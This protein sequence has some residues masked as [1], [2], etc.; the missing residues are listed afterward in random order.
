MD[1]PFPFNLPLTSL[2]YMLLYLI[3]FVTH[4]L[5]MHYVVAGC[6]S[7][8]GFSFWYRQDEGALLHNP[9]VRVLRDWMPFALSAAITFGVAP[10]LFVQILVPL[11]FYTANLL[12]GWRWMVVIPALMAAFYLLYVLKSTWFERLRWWQRALVAGL[13]AGLFVFIGFCWTANHLVSSEPSAWTEA[14]ASGELPLKVLPVVSRSLVWLSVAFVSMATLL[15]AQLAYLREG[16]ATDDDLPTVGWLRWFAMA[17][18]G[19][20]GVASLAAIAFSQPGFGAV[21][22]LS[23]TLWLVLGILFWAGQ[24]YLWHSDSQATSRRWI[25]PRL[26]LLPGMLFCGAVVRELIHVASIDYAATLAGQAE[27]GKVEGFWVF[28]ITAVIVIGLM[29]LTIRWVYQSFE[30]EPAEVEPS[31]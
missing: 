21:A 30:T 22:N 16:T 28:L 5:A 11:H 31:E 15:T 13:N 20:F 17:G 14:F 10:L 29:A 18:L 3:T 9:I 7:I 24:I 12:L 26:V 19:T 25:V 2:T 23:G 6:L 8:V 1:A 27:A 4:H